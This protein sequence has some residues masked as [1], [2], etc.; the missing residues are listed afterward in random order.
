MIRGFRISPR[1]QPHPRSTKPL[2]HRKKWY[3]LIQKCGLFDEDFYRSYYG[4]RTPIR[5]P[6]HHFM[7]KGDRAGLN[8]LP[9]FDTKF[10]RRK[11]GIPDAANT[12]VHYLTQGSQQL[13][14]P[15]PLF[16][17]SFYLDQIGCIPDHE[18]LLG[19]F[20]KDRTYSANPNRA[21]DSR[22]Y[23]RC[24]GECDELEMNPLVHYVVV[25]AR[26]HYA[27][28]PEFDPAFYTANN[29][30]FN[31]S[32]KYEPLSHFLHHNKE[33]VRT[34]RFFNPK[35]DMHIAAQ[36]NQLQYAARPVVL[37]V[38]TNEQLHDKI[39]LQQLAA[40]NHG[41]SSFMVGITCDHIVEQVGSTEAMI[42]LIYPEQHH[43]AHFSLPDQLHDFIGFLE[44][45]GAS[46]FH[47]C[48][49]LGTIFRYWWLLDRLNLPFDI[50]VCMRGDIRLNDDGPWRQDYG[51]LTREAEKI[52]ARTRLLIS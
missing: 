9:L 14:D 12:L 21:F 16:D 32:E 8:P 19:H 50:D 4:R 44:L 13:L 26:K 10:Y 15:H 24:H 29:N 42:G 5:D 40:Q 51:K 6:I 47:F 11:H 18:T 17:S 38:G 41:P 43:F 36:F 3:S 28:S 27:T 25:G 22:Y 30:L 7:E 35:T 48:Y 20:L 1:H 23:V 2:P 45:S 34:T 31:R 33:A 46:R 39:A 52:V 37:Y 49:Q